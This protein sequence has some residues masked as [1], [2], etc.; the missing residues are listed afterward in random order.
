MKF[1]E[2]LRLEHPEID[3][4]ER[5]TLQEKCPEDYGYEEPFDCPK[6]LRCK[7]CWNR[8]M[9]EEEIPE[10]EEMKFKV[11]D[12]VQLEKGLD[13]NKTYAGLIFYNNMRF[14]GSAKITRVT[15]SGSYVIDANGYEYFYSPEMLEPCVK[16]MTAEEAWETARRIVAE[17]K[18]FG[19]LSYLDLNEI[20]G[21]VSLSEIITGYTASEAAEKIRK[22]EESKEI[23]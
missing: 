18:E 2:K 6:Y 11:G 9:P 7:D 5:V 20:F 13:E 1:I 8:E 21:T 23:R 12:E 22:W 19:G 15:E 16:E 17:P 4:V 3:N 14:A 10:E